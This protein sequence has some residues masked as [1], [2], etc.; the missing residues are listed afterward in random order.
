MVFT[1]AEAGLFGRFDSVGVTDNRNTHHRAYIEE[2]ADVTYVDEDAGLRIG[3]AL[4]LRLE[5]DDGGSP[6]GEIYHL[7]GEHT[8]HSKG[9]SSVKVGRMQRSD[10]LG[11]Y[12]LDGTEL[13]GKVSQFGAQGFSLYVGQ[14]RRIDDF[15]M[16]EADLLLGGEIQWGNRP[17]HY[18]LDDIEIKELGG[19]IE[20]QHL[21]KGESQSRINWSINGDGTLHQNRLSDLKLGFGGSY[22]IGQRNLEELLLS[23]VA[24]RG[25]DEYLKL[26]YQSYSPSSPT[27]TFREQYYALYALGRQSEFAASYRLHPK[28]SLS[29]GIKGRLVTR[30]DGLNGIGL[31]GTVSRWRYV[32]IDMNAQLDLLKLGHDSATTLYLEGERPLT[33]MRRLRMALV[34][35]NQK[36]ALAGDNNAFGI[37]GE[38]EQMLSSVLYLG[39]TFMHTWN[40]RLMDEYRY[41]VRLSYRFDDRTEWQS[42]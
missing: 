17:L 7:Y 2:Q 20:L 28:N 8:L 29:R 16:V 4:S 12:T 35:Q 5:D 11:F 21:R 14:P 31:T 41:G 37:D 25:R 18:R 13:R 32:R 39:V 1:R 24:R 23:A 19:R 9:L 38:L 36:K 40:S 22:Q 42:E 15:H 30:E 10:A 6:Q 27:L 34:M 26:E 33:A 3:A